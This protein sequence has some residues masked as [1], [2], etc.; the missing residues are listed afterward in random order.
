MSRKSDRD[1]QKRQ[2]RKRKK[3]EAKK[4]SQGRGRASAEPSAGDVA[5]LF[6]IGACH[7]L[8]AEC[9]PLDDVVRGQLLDAARSAGG[10]WARLP[11]ELES[12]LC[13]GADWSLT[14]A[15]LESVR[16]AFL[17]H[18]AESAFNRL[19]VLATTNEPRED[20]FVAAVAGE[21]DCAARAALAFQAL[22]GALEDPTQ[23][24]APALRGIAIEIT[25]H[26]DP[27]DKAPSRIYENLLLAS[28]ASL[29]LPP[30]EREQAVAVLA[31]SCERVFEHYAGERSHTAWW[32]SG[33]LFLAEV[34]GRHAQN[35]HAA[36]LAAHPALVAELFGAG[37]GALF[38]TDLVGSPEPLRTVHVQTHADTW[39]RL[40]ERRIDPGAL[41]FE[42][43]LH[44]EIARMKLLAQVHL[45]SASGD[46]APRGF[47]AAFAQLRALL[48]HGVPPASRALAETIAPALV[49][50]YV[51]AID[52]LGA[53]GA[54]LETT[55]A[56]HEANP[57]NFRLACL[58]ATGVLLRDKRD[59]LRALEGR[60]PRA[61][62]DPEFFARSARD[63]AILARGGG[64]VAAIRRLLFDPLDREHRKR[65]LLRLS[66][67]A[68][69]HSAKVADYDEEL[70]R[71]LPYFERENFV[72]REMRE[73]TALESGLL[74]LATMMAP[75]HGTKVSLDDSQS[76]QW[77]SYAREVARRSTFGGR[78]IERHLRK[79][80]GFTLTA[81]VR[82]AL[83]ADI[84]A[85]HGA[86]RA[87]PRPRHERAAQS[88]RE[89]EL[90]PQPP[91]QPGL[92]DVP[93]P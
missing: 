91:L 35:G 1:R 61:Q 69:L 12:F 26:S 17:R 21:H 4:R 30:A 46:A 92:F 76:Q 44:Y 47:L 65:C 60:I 39:L 5:V 36:G 53:E 83:L 59:G 29:Q 45:Q 6:C 80:R 85:S 86:A 87:N 71:L 42:E 32:Q 7:Q 55:A 75:L 27:D 68:L 18:G 57:E 24:T 8:L 3:R 77:A 38:L 14:C 34:F 88:S 11:F 19:W 74:F 84:G 51:H 52:E 28:L 63:W 62:I 66:E 82:A 15:D 40:L 37:E 90:T 89:P 31:R 67:Q 2:Q 81:S 9:E 25:R 33:R 13:D 93:E 41:D 72:Y 49:D 54:A 10:I 23:D 20:L 58:Y 16:P 73:S 79:P 70:R 56:L 48:A 22:R 64:T 78:L 43:R 50:F